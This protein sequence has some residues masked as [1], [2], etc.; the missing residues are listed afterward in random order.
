M[1]RHTPAKGC[2]LVWLSV[3]GHAYPLQVLSVPR[4]ALITKWT[5]TYAILLPYKMCVPSCVGC[6]NTEWERVSEEKCTHTCVSVL[7]LVRRCES[8]LLN[9]YGVSLEEAEDCKW[10]CPFCC[11]S[12]NCSLCRKKVCIC[13]CVPVY[14]VGGHYVSWGELENRK[15]TLF[16]LLPLLKLCES[17][18]VFPI[19]LKV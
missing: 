9:R 15:T 2:P 12:C 14:R 3:T 4:W 5:I 13:L 11:K 1:A 18:R 6:S 7:V 19:Y 16:K 10:S 17:W 8:C